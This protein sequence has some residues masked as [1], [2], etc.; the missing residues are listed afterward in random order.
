MPGLLEGHDAA[1]GVFGGSLGK[2]L[3][4]RVAGA[5]THAGAKTPESG[6]V[7]RAAGGTEARDGDVFFQGKRGGHDLAVDGA[8]R[9]GTQWALASLDQAAEQ[10]RLAVGRVDRQGRAVFDHA[11]F[12]G[13]GGA[14][15][16]EPEKLGVEG[17]DQFPKGVEVG[18]EGVL[19][20]KT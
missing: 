20:F 1:I 15:V 12:L 13:E 10:F 16:Q 4:H 7:G 6:L 18:H 9:L 14:L 5:V 2:N 17:V 11:D 8:D 19:S 3:R